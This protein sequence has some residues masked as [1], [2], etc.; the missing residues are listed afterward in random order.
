MSFP[1]ANRGQ[2]RRL[3]KRFTI[4]PFEVGTTTRQSGNFPWIRLVETPVTMKERLGAIVTFVVA[5]RVG[6]ST[7]S[8]CFSV[9]VD[10]M[11]YREKAPMLVVGSTARRRWLR[12]PQRRSCCMIA[13]KSNNDNN[14]LMPHEYLND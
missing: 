14:T 4:A 11:Q 3:A 9:I 13:Y 7:S 2:S 1:T 10:A 6:N 8:Y 12:E 5:G